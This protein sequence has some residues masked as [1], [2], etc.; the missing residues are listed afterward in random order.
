MD[1]DACW[2]CGKYNCT[3]HRDYPQSTYSPPT[4]S[5]PPAPQYSY[6]HGYEGKKRCPGRGYGFTCSAMID[7]DEHCCQNCHY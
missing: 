1:A 4:H 6:G 7:A 5:P 2:G 3:C